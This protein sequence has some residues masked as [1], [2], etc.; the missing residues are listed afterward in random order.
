MITRRSMDALLVS[1]AVLP[2]TEA[3]AAAAAPVTLPEPKRF[4]L[5]LLA[6]QSN[7]AGRGDVEPADKEPIAQVVA[8][9]ATGEWVPATDPVHWDKPSAGVGLARA[10]A[11]EYS[12]THPGVTVGLVPAACGGS[13]IASW[14]PGQYFEDT[15]SHPYDDAIARAKRAMTL[16]TLRGI[17]WHQGESDRSPALAPRY[18]Q[19]LRTLIARFREELRAPSVPFLIGQLGQFLGS[20]EWDEPTRQI[21]RA[22][23]EVAKSVPLCA[24]VPSHGLSSK[25][26]NLH[27][28]ARSLRE[29][30]KR[31]AAALASLKTV[32]EGSATKT[33][34]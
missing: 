18:E 28:D 7:M 17:L 26:D 8:L 15:K 9:N 13:P 23:R 21:D 20:G 32:D 11:S 29:F 33:K 31:Y 19:A 1:L 25:P 24:F 30:G 16:G 22:Q 12:R 2:A 14:A 5:F 10:F 4:H 27:F 6:G 34:R 3:L